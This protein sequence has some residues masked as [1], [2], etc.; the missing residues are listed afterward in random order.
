[1]ATQEFPWVQPIGGQKIVWRPLK[2]GDHIDLDANYG[3]SDMAHLKRYATLAARIISVDGKAKQEFSGDLVNLREWEDY[4]LIAFNE[5]IESRELARSVALAPQRPGGVVM[6]LEQA[7]TKAQMA[8][9]ELGQ[10]LT[11]VLE[12]AKEAEQ[13]LGPLK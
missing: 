12:R 5:E 2:V 6:S 1:M 7:V 13:K 4:D 3:R 8:A 11:A 10:A 9:N